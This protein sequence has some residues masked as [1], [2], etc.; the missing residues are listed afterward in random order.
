M[1][2]WLVERFTLSGLLMRR[3]IAVES[4]QESAIVAGLPS[5][6]TGTNPRLRHS[7]H[8]KSPHRAPADEVSREGAVRYLSHMSG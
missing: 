4:R 7:G 8:T 3:G 1:E 5:A 2:L 6:A